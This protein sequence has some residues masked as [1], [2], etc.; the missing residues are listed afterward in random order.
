MYST[1]RSLPSNLP[2]LS[3]P[4]FPRRSY[5]RTRPASRFIP[6]SRPTVAIAEPLVPPSRGTR[7]LGYSVPAFVLVV[8]ITLLCALIPRL[9]SPIAVPIPT[10]HTPVPSRT[11]EQWMQG[12]RGR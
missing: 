5:H 4:P 7:I 2:T 6:A 3:A 11:P 1:S 10:H 8:V 9:T 12:L